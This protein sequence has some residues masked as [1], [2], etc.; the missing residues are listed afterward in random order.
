MARRPTLCQLRPTAVERT[1]PSD[2]PGNTRRRRREGK[3]SGRASTK[4]D[5]VTSTYSSLSSRLERLGPRLLHHPTLLHHPRLLH[6]ATLLH[7]LTLLHQSRRSGGA[8]S[9]NLVTGTR[10]APTTLLYRSTL[11]RNARRRISNAH[12][13]IGSRERTTAEGPTAVLPPVL[14]SCHPRAPHRQRPRLQLTLPARS[15]RTRLRPPNRDPSKLLLS[16]RT[17]PLR[18][19]TLPG[20]GLPTTRLYFAIDL[21]PLPFR[22]A[23]GIRTTRA[24]ILATF[25]V[26]LK[27][28]APIRLAISASQLQQADRRPTTHDS[29]PGSR[30]SSASPCK[31]A[32][33]RVVWRYCLARSLARTSNLWLCHTL[34]PTH[35]LNP[36]TELIRAPTNDAS[37]WLLRTG[38]FSRT[39][40]GAPRS[41]VPSPFGFL[42]ALLRGPRSIAFCRCRSSPSSSFAYHLTLHCSLIRDPVTS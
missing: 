6:H 40:R 23:G 7:H 42:F 26:R 5:S 18:T 30:L 2:E 21:P 39:R 1:G 29:Q 16:I 10:N 17:L 36:D 32:N 11:A 27:I 24:G 34:G 15:T 41:R 28:P 31:S 4:R 38:E 9:A 33:S 13:S 8:T 12:G 19:R 20:L 37:S 25:R 3:T 14:A 22:T 35:T